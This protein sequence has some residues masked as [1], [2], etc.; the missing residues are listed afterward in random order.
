MRAACMCR[1]GR[2]APCASYLQ[3][4][5]LTLR[6]AV[7]QD[8]QSIDGVLHMECMQPDA[9]RTL[10]HFAKVHAHLA[11]SLP[12]SA[13]AQQLSFYLSQ[14][15]VPIFGIIDTDPPSNPDQ[16]S[17]VGYIM[18]N[19][20]GGTLDETLFKLQYDSAPGA[21]HA[22]LSMMTVGWS[23]VPAHSAKRGAAAPLPPSLPLPLPLSLCS[24]CMLWP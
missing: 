6:C 4:A 16:P 20:T 7:L 18:L 12:G 3:A 11:Y 9:K 13:A 1:Q 17:W 22:T 10:L 24:I 8:G 14:S 5:A 19:L 23:M 21:L 2:Y 15:M